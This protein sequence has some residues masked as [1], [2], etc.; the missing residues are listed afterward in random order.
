M[1]AAT[2]PRLSLDA[3]PGRS[4]AEECIAKALRSRL[5]LCPV[6]LTVDVYPV[7]T[8]HF[9]P[10]GGDAALT[11]VA[12]GLPG[13]QVFR[14]TGATLVVLLDT[15]DSACR[16]LGGLPDLFSVKFDNEA[17]PIGVPFSVR[18]GAFPARMRESAPDLALRIDRW[19]AAPYTHC[20]SAL[21]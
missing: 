3:L 12:R 15:L 5:P 17:D 11:A 2:A 20:S 8:E 4:K 14:W 19:V 13:A 1:F 18:T 21:S 16:M 6:A 10:S 9:G 7:I